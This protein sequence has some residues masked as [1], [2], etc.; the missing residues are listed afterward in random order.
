MLINA[1]PERAQLSVHTLHP[2]V[3]AET[4]S[5]AVPCQVREDVKQ[6]E[7]ARTGGGGGFYHE[8]MRNHCFRWESGLLDILNGIVSRVLEMFPGGI[9]ENGPPYRNVHHPRLS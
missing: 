8:L 4:T 5:L 6:W 9:Q 7:G 3:G 2:Q 1:V